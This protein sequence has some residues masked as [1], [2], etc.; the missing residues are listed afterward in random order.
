MTLGYVLRPVR[1]LP[2]LR[3]STSE[4]TRV[5]LQRRPKRS[6]TTRYLY[7]DPALCRWTA[8]PDMSTHP[9]EST[10]MANRMCLR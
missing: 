3:D 8:E 7:A 2:L 10:D 1:H 6:P 9:K 5:R 4:R